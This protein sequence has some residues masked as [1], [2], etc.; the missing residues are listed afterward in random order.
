[1][2]LS[3]ALAV[4]ACRRSED[5]LDLARR[6][7]DPL[8]EISEKGEAEGPGL[9]NIIYILA[10]DLGYGDLGCYGQEKISTPHLDALAEEGIRFTLAFRR[11]LWI[12][13]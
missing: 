5:L 13:D 8:L 7:K 10:D 12:R 9:P 3:S 11:R 4:A 2:E 6:T 1:M